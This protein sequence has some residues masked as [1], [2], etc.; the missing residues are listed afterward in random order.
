M[1]QTAKKHATHAFSQFRLT[2]NL[3]QNLYK[4]EITPTAKL[5]LL[6]LSSCYNP[7]KADMFPK[8]K[9]IAAKLGISEASVIRAISE[10]HKEGL[11]ISE[12]KYTNRYKFTSKI[13]SEQPQNEKI[14]EIDILQGETSQNEI[15]ETCKMQPHDIQPMSKPIKQPQSS[16]DDKYLLQYAKMKKAKNPQKYIEAIKK[17]GGADE[18]IREMKVIETNAQGMVAKAKKVQEDLEFARANRAENVPVDFF[19][20]VKLNLLRSGEKCILGK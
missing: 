17:L 10:L 20:R 12:R 11:I 2:N 18:V 4:H 1:A 7:K 8:Q 14:F 9:T 6:Y 5:V 16:S 19:Q 15:R 13:V 3:L